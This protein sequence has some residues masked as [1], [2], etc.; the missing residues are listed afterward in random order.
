MSRDQQSGSV[1]L[2]LADVVLPDTASQE[3]RDT[4]ARLTG[5]HEELVDVG[6]AAGMVAAAGYHQNRDGLSQAFSELANARGPQSAR[7]PALHVHEVRD[8]SGGIEGARVLVD[9]PPQQ[10]DIY[11]DEQNLLIVAAGAETERMLPFVPR[12]MEYACDDDDPHTDIMLRPDPPGNYERLES[13]P[14][15]ETPDDDGDDATDTDVADA[16]GEVE[17]VD[18]GPDELDLDSDDDPDPDTQEDG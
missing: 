2:D 13:E 5:G 16:V 8:E 6:A 17:G 4:L 12:D 3:L 1:I 14:E 9:V 11:H 18:A 7:E 10:V 15:L